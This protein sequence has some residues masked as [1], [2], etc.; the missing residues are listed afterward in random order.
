[1]AIIHKPTQYCNC[2]PAILI[3]ALTGI[4][5]SA[6]AAPGNLSNVPLY[7]GTSA[8]PNI[9]F[10]IDDSG[11]MD[12]EVMTRDLNNSGRFTGTQ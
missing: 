8:E 6:V 10:T 1:M 9:F 7:L 2:L 11:S 3:A 5:T 4:S 12:W